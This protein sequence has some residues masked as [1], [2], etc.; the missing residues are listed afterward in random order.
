MA[1]NMIE[2]PTSQ[3]L[4]LPWSWCSRCQRAYVTGTCRLVRFSPDAIHPHPTTLKLCPYDDCSGSTTRDGW[5]WETILMQH[6]QHPVTP[7]RNVIYARAP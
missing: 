3:G 5:L 4:H 2:S 1:Y 7:E 6:P